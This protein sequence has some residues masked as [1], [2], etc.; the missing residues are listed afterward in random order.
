MAVLSDE[1]CSKLLGHIEL[2]TT[3]REL[4]DDGMDMRF[5]HSAL[6]ADAATVRSLADSVHAQIASAVEER[7]DAAVKPG[8]MA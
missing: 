5:C 4:K 3:L 6:P 2:L 1:A 7:S 8:H